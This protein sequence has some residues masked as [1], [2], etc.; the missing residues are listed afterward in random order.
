[1]DGTTAGGAAEVRVIGNIRA[2]TATAT[3]RLQHDSR[4]SGN[5]VEIS[6]KATDAFEFIHRNHCGVNGI[7]SGQCP[8]RLED[9]PRLVHDYPRDSEN[10]REKA[11]RV[12]V[13]QLPLCPTIQSPVTV[14]DLLENLGVRS[15]CD[16]VVG[17]PLEERD[18]RGLIRMRRARRVHQHIGVSQGQGRD[19]AGGTDSNSISS[20]VPT[21]RCNAA[22]PATAARRSSRVF[23]KY[24]RRQASAT[25]SPTLE[26]RARANAAS[27][28]YKSGG[29]RIVVFFIRFPQSCAATRGGPVEWL[30]PEAWA[31]PALP[32][33]AG[34]ADRDDHSYTP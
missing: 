5:S 25:S 2:K 10:V 16:P 26:D 27:W 20:V 11:S 7:S 9:R 32:A 28:S 22:S 34:R 21:G 30:P 19:S 17:H 12:I 23:R 6:I 24:W 15:G 33:R 14:Q 31:A 18:G 3:A 13:N 8:I 1:M 29:K 4:A